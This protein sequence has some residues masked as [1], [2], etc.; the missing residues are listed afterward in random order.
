MEA[1]AAAADLLSDADAV[2]DNRRVMHVVTYARDWAPVNRH[3]AVL[4]QD[5]KKHK[6]VVDRAT[7]TR[8]LNVWR[9]RPAKKT[10]NTLSIVVG[11]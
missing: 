11:S 8:S 9:L 1:A 6:D 3:R 7:S 5:W 10:R 2:T 4:W